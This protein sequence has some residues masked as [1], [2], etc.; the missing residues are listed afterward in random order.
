MERIFLVWQESSSLGAHTPMLMRTHLCSRFNDNNRRLGYVAIATVRG[1]TEID[2]D[3][4]A[5]WGRPVMAA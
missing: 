3:T 4:G 1:A 2:A 5:G